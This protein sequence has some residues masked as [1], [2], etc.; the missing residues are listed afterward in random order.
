MRMK[1]GVGM[2]G[3]A[4]DLVV[5]TCGKGTGDTQGSLDYI[6]QAP[7]GGTTTEDFYFYG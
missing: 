2:C 1:R 7:A 6:T 3:V 5:V 4:R